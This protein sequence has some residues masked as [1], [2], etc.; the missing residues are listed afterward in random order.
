L[1]VHVGLLCAI[2]S[3]AVIYNIY[4][5]TFI[6]FRMIHS[7][8]ALVVTL[9]ETPFNLWHLLF[10]KRT[11]HEMF[12]CNLLGSVK[13][14]IRSDSFSILINLTYFRRRLRV[15]MR[16]NLLSDWSKNILPVFS[17]TGTE[18]RHLLNKLM[19]LSLYTVTVQTNLDTHVH[20][21]QT[22]FICTR[23]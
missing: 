9:K 17:H 14:E 12:F 4:N 19:L 21:W 16:W 15:M 20:H 2:D 8:V 3:I 22:L 11:L 23:I 13:S 5:I 10:D 1:K 18:S 7:V 6:V